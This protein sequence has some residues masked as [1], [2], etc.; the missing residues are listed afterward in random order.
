[1]PYQDV[2]VT[3]LG[4]GCGTRLYPLTKLR[5]K[6]ATDAGQTS[7]RSLDALNLW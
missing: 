2:I 4:G 5:T 6:P 3:V 7:R 1:M